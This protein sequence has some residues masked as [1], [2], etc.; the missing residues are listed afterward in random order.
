MTTSEEIEKYR[1]LIAA[2]DAKIVD[3]VE[4]I[5]DTIAQQPAFGTLIEKYLA[6]RNW[7]N[8]DDE[9]S[10]FLRAAKGTVSIEKDGS[11]CITDDDNC[12]DY[13]YEPKSE[14]GDLTTI[15]TTAQ[16]VAD[17]VNAWAEKN[18][19][20][21]EASQRV[22]TFTVE[23]TTDTVTHAHQVIAERLSY[24]EE[25][26][27]ELGQEFDYSISPARLVFHTTV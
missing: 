11:I 16:R 17:A 13:S 10:M 21:V 5:A 15:E 27:D 6:W 19:I 24:D 14:Y 12:C 7:R 3:W 25:L 23:V 1:D 20:G 18:N 4:E 9:V 2:H 26:T 8:R 22:Y